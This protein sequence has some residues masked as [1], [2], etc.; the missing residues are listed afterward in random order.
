MQKNT[1]IRAPVTQ[2]ALRNVYCLMEYNRQRPKLLP[3]GITIPVEKYI[4]TL[5]KYFYKLS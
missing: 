3:E 1:T 5:Q 4:K 2:Q